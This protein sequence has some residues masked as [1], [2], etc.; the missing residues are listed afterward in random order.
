MLEK[1]LWTKV[2][3][4]VEVYTT[5]VH[6]HQVWNTISNFYGSSNKLQFQSSTYKFVSLAHFKRTCFCIKILTP[7]NELNI[8]TKISH[9]Q[10]QIAKK[11][12]I[13]NLEILLNTWHVRTQRRKKL[14]LIEQQPK[15]GEETLSLHYAAVDWLVSFCC[16]AL[17][18]VYLTYVIKQ[19]I[20]ALRLHSLWICKHIS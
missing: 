10:M 9:H 3:R 20:S 14:D 6:N 7:I 17:E 4:Y 12:T 19:A 13:L 11:N 1:K 8:P 2:N 15:K 16:F 18:I 5:R